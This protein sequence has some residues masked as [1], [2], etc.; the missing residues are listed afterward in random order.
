MKELNEMELNMVAGGFDW[1]QFGA[2]LAVIGLGIAIVGTAGLASVPL[3]VAGAATIGEIGVGL[4][5]LGLAGAGGY[6]SGSSFAENSSSNVALQVVT[7][8]G[9]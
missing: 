5:G 4:T 1:E 7:T 8:I 6:I 3:A 2:G 9:E